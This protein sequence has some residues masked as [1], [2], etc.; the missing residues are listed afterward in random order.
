MAALTADACIRSIRVASHQY[1]EAEG[2][3][4]FLVRLQGF[5]REPRRVVGNSLSTIAS[6]KFR[7]CRTSLLHQTMDL[8]DLVRVR[9]SAERSM[10]CNGSTLGSLFIHRPY[11]N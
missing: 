7:G 10:W 2:R 9:A 3:G 5:F 6:K 4:Y 1:S 8:E 11:K